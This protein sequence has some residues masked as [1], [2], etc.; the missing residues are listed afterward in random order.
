L[1][2]VI[3][4]SYSGIYDH[5]VP[6]WIG[7]LVC[8]PLCLELNISLYHFGIGNQPV[9]LWNQWQVCATLE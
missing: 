2:S 7:R 4:P 8:V 1:E 3:S 9:S 5:V 6:L